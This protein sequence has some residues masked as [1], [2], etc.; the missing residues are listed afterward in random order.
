MSIRT[1]SSSSQKQKSSLDDLD[2]VSYSN[3]DLTITSL[4][5]IKANN[6]EFKNT[7]DVKLCEMTSDSHLDIQGGLKIGS[8]GI[9][10]G[11]Y[12]AVLKQL[13]I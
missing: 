2:G 10:Y 8:G 13:F 5:T 3:G 9:T 1:I 4:D 12:S 6:I 7:S 11:S